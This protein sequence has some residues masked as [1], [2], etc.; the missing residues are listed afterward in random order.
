MATT[1]EKTGEIT[2]PTT[3]AIQTAEI[4]AQ[5]V[6][7][8]GRHPVPFGANDGTHTNSFQ[9]SG[10]QFDTSAGAGAFCF[11]LA[12]IKENDGAL[13]VTYGKWASDISNILARLVAPAR[14]GLNCQV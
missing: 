9:P 14:E 11:I 2:P 1:D 3:A 12:S 13:G 10:Q 4:A 5:G 6:I 7:S 8:Y